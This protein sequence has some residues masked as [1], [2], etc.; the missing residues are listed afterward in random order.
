[1]LGTY[2]R[3]VHTG[4]RERL[5]QSEKELKRK[6]EEALFFWRGSL[7]R[8]M[9]NLV[10]VSP[11]LLDSR[12][13]QHGENVWGYDLKSAEQRPKNNQV[14]AGSSR[15]LLLQGEEEG[16][17]QPLGNRAVGLAEKIGPIWAAGEQ[18]RGQER[19]NFRHPM[20]REEGYFIKSQWIPGVNNPKVTFSLMLCFC[21][22]QLVDLLTILL[23]PTPA[24]L[25]SHHVSH[26]GESALFLNTQGTNKK[27]SQSICMD[28]CSR[29]DWRLR[30]MEGWTL[31]S[32]HFLKIEQKP[33]SSKRSWPNQQVG[34]HPPPFPFPS[35]CFWLCSL[36]LLRSKR[37]IHL[38]SSQML[39]SKFKLSLPQ[40]WL[41]WPTLL[42]CPG[43]RGFPGCGTSV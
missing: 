35:L 18:G 37:Q 17:V 19:G 28:L 26:D 10:Q 11:G 41:G 40:T 24:I 31:Q 43:W 42:L 16:G 14:H 8:A 22:L 21:L 33:S 7:N 27:L 4:S 6:P 2:Q 32:E 38:T 23:C 30:E 20:D 13:P 34:P 12:G 5:I 29:L 39:P 1:M 3:I 9:M 25:V 15:E 36:F